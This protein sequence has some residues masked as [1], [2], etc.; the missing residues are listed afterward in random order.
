[1]LSDKNTIGVCVGKGLYND[2]FSNWKDSVAPWKHTPKPIAK[3]QITCSDGTVEKVVSDTS[4]TVT[5]VPCIF[6]HSRQGVVYDANLCEK[7]DIKVK[8]G[9]S[10]GIVSDGEH[11]FEF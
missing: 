9:S 3:I 6:N 2:N 1:M 4:R 8:I 11:T 7:W 10:D 5:H